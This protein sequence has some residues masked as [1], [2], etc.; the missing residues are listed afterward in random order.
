MGDEVELK[1]MKVDVD[2]S[3]PQENV[4][5]PMQNSDRLTAADDGEHI[6]GRFRQRT[7]RSS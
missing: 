4:V 2:G 1:N 6:S 7:F 5:N 3:M